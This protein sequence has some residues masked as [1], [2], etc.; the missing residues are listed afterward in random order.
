MPE[1]QGLL[2]PVSSQFVHSAYH[3]LRRTGYLSIHSKNPLQTLHLLIGTSLCEE[4]DGTIACIRLS[5]FIDVDVKMAHWSWNN[6]YYD[7]D[8]LERTI[9]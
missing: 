2:F 5:P 8:V 9:L 1:Q 7:I 4:D 6:P 3:V